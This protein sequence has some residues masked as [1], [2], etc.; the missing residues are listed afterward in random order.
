[1]RDS[2]VK[3]VNEDL[4]ELLPKIDINVK[5]I[6]GEKDVIVPLSIGEE[7]N[8]KFKDSQL[9]VFKDAGHNMLRRQSNEITKIIKEL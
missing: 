4:S 2:L 7:A 5:L 6:W 3:T 8:N 1:M 9:T